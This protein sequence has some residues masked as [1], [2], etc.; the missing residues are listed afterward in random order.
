MKVNTDKIYEPGRYF[1]GLGRHFLKFP[2]Y[3]QILVFSNSL[4]EEKSSLPG[5]QFEESS[6]FYPTIR[7]RTKYIFLKIIS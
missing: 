3:T 7:A 4:Q 6:T 1:L 2:K 5:A